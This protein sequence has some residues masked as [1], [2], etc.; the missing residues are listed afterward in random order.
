VQRSRE[1][2]RERSELRRFF[3]KLDDIAFSRWTGLDLRY[4]DFAP[5]TFLELDPEVVEIILDPAA[6]AEW[7]AELDRD[8]IL[9]DFNNFSNRLRA[10]V[11]VELLDGGLDLSSIS[12]FSQK[13]FLCG[14]VKSSLAINLRSGPLAKSIE[15]LRS[16]EVGEVVAQR[17]MEFKDVKEKGNDAWFSELCFCILTANSTARL[18]L[19]IQSDLGNAFLTLPV[20]ELTHRLKSL[21]HRFYNR[22]AEFIVSARKYSRIKDIITGFPETKQAREWLVEN[23]CGI[24]WKEASHFLRNVGYDDVAILDRHILALLRENGIIKEAP[25]TLTRRR[26]LEIEEL[27]KD[28]AKKVD[29]SPGEMDL[30]MW[31]MKTHCVLK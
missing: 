9:I 21:G 18:G 31:C 7:P 10:P 11:P 13:V 1:S 22:R 3:A 16:S 30:Y 12:H 8:T 2:R 19:K 28:L 26:Y 17:M 15:E 6:H 24:G 14:A 27:F 25:K 5:D 4:P 29:L 20:E 23:V